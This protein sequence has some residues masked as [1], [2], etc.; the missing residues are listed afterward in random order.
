MNLEERASTVRLRV[1]DAVGL[2]LDF[3][4]QP[5]GNIAAIEWILPLAHGQKDHQSRHEQNSRPEHQHPHSLYRQSHGPLHT[6]M[7]SLNKLLH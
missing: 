1:G 3:N 2:L 4:A 5:L 6:L 7:N